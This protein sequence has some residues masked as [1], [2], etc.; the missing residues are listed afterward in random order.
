MICSR[1]CEVF[2]VTA[3]MKVGGAQY[4]PLKGGNYRIEVLLAFFSTLKLLLEK[5]DLWSFFLVGIRKQ[6]W[7]RIILISL[8]WSTE[9]YSDQL[10]KC[11]QMCA[12]TAA[13]QGLTFFPTH[14]ATHRQKIVLGWI[15]PNI[16]KK[17][18]R[19]L[20]PSTKWQKWALHNSRL[21]W[22]KQCGEK[23]EKSG[24]WH[25]LLCIYLKKPKPE[26]V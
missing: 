25:R 7:S 8:W 9:N 16:K 21:F 22:G 13:A 19:N 10:S 12:L 6:N 14:V 2:N 5:V 4:S 26:N 17:V 23:N 18:D 11:S 15:H 1:Y 20:S 3:N 24:L